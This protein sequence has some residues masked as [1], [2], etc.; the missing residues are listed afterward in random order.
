MRK[1]TIGLFLLVAVLI[2][3]VWI[4]RP[5][6]SFSTE[7]VA[8]EI[9]ALVPPS[10]SIETAYFMDGGSVGVAITDSAGKELL[11]CIPAPDHKT[12]Y[13]G[14]I[15]YKDDGATPFEGPGDS[16]IKLLEILRN[17][18]EFTHHNDLAVATVSGRIR[19][20]LRIFYRSTTKQYHYTMYNE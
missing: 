11:A 3:T 6:K 9:N 16:I 4:Y 7:K 14:A 12:L 17:H 8:P 20:W 5:Y 13:L 2:S 19:D 10:Q 1:K 18:D 15:H